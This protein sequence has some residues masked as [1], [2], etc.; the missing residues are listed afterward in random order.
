[1]KVTFAPPFTGADPEGVAMG[2]NEPR[3]SAVGAGI[4][5]LK[6]P[7]AYGVGGGA[8]SLPSL[9]RGLGRMLCPSPKNFSISELKKAV[10]GAFWD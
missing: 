4:E 8:P 6:G 5:A 7:R 2:E 3:S 1:L 10:F 9:G